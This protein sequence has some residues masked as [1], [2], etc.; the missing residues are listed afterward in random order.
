MNYLN[1]F[2]CFLVSPVNPSFR[3]EFSLIFISINYISIV[4]GWYYWLFKEK[5][6]KE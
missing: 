6:K 3:Y 5:N 2:Q 4:P 1:S